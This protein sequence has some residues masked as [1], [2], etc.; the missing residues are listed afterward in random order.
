[1]TIPG[2]GVITAAALV[3]CKR[4]PSD[5][6]SGRRFFARLGL[7]PRRHATWNV[8]K[9]GAISKAGN[10]APCWM[11]IHGDRSI[12]RWRGVS[13]A[14]RKRL[15]GR[16][17]AAIAAAAIVAKAARVVWSTLRYGEL[18]GQPAPRMAWSGRPHRLRRADADARKDDGETGRADVGDVRLSHRDSR[19]RR[20]IGNRLAD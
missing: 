13:W 17:P 4:D 6:M 9:F 10:G 14:R 19:S 5:V 12:M 18:Y 8:E 15:R 16:H 1:M 7:A 2:V 20:M 3:D 11:L